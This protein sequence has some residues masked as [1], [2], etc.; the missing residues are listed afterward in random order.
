M[1]REELA[2]AL[3]ESDCWSHGLDKVRP[4][5][6][7]NTQGYFMAADRMFYFIQKQREIPE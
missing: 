2:R 5:E 4:Y 1:T 7:R 3:F 6:G